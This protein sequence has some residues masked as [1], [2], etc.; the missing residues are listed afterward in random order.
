MGN[1]KR[2]TDYTSKG[3]KTPNENQSEGS[4]TPKEVDNDFSANRL[5]N[6]LDANV[7]NVSTTNC[8]P[9]SMNVTERHS[10]LKYPK[11]VIRHR[12][13]GSQ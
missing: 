2:S 13:K 11:V 10:N 5:R 9:Q 6:L 12:V 8:S 3:K 4:C 1:A 7:T